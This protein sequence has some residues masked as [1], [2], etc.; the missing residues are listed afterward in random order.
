MISKLCLSILISCLL[1]CCGWSAYTYSI[2][3]TRETPEY[4]TLFYS[5]NGH[6]FTLA[7]CRIF[8]WPNPAALAHVYLSHGHLFALA[9]CRILRLPNPTALAHMYSSH[10][11]PFALAHWSI[12]NDYPWLHWNTSF[13]LMGIH[14]LWP[15]AVY[16]DDHPQLHWHT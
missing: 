16:W 10:G 13:H 8:R 9:H 6:L 15:T 7:H 12:L 4:S 3:S 11:H 14:L 2:R 1:A 5:S